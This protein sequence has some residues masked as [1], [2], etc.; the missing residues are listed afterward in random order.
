MKMAFCNRKGRR[1]FQQY[2]KRSC[3]LLFILDYLEVVVI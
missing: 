2:K 1:M 3:A